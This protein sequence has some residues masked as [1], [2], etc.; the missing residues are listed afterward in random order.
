M[1]SSDPTRP[2]HADI[3]HKI[4]ELL[5]ARKPGATICP[6]EVAR[7]LEADTWKPLMPQIREI[8]RGLAHANRISVTRGGVAV[9]ATAAG[10]P[11]RLGLA[12]GSDKGV[13]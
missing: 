8:A 4:F 7:A 2:T 5:A 6:S 9:D 1:T 3:E 13:R 11:I 10:G 12:G